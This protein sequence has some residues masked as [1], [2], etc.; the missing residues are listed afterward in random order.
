MKIAIQM[1]EIS[2]INVVGDTSFA[3]MLE[4]QNLGHDLYYYTPD[5]LSVIDKK[6]Y[7]WV[8]PIKVYDRV[9]NYY[10]LGDLQKVDLAS[11]DVILLRQDPPFDMNYITTTHI[12][13]FISK[14]VL[15][16]NDPF[17]VRNSPEKLFVMEFPYFMPKTLVARDVKDVLEFR[18][19]VGDVIIKPLYGNGGA[20]VFYLK[21]GDKNLNALI[22]LFDQYYSQPFVVQE[23]LPE[24]SNGDKRIILVDGVVAGALNRIAD[25]KDI[26]SNMHVGGKAVAANITDEENGICDAIGPWLRERKLYLT[27]IDVIGGKITEINVTSPTGVREIKKFGGCD[28]AQLFW[29]KIEK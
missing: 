26:R 15:I 12:L 10:S 16:L 19:A 24:V 25:S 1:D 3:L 27:G 5:K 8:Y 18:A 23:Y 9:Q 28:I 11:M 21:I 13:D 17:W 29:Q 14:E 4:A 2:K 20:G 6:V 22:E 7:A